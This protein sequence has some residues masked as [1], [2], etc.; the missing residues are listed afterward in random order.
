LAAVERTVVDVVVE[1]LLTT[2]GSVA[3]EMTVVDVPVDGGGWRLSCR[4]RELLGV[5]T[6]D[7][8]LASV[9]MTREAADTTSYP[10][11]GVVAPSQK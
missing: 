9:S 5:A 3:V 2:A 10:N 8:C 6:L 7:T 4:R 1:A 11:K